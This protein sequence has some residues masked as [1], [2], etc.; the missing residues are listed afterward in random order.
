MKVVINLDLLEAERDVPKKVIKAPS[1][2]SHGEHKLLWSN[3]TILICN[4]SMEKHL[5]N[6]VWTER[7]GE[8]LQ[9][10]WCVQRQPHSRLDR[11][12]QMR[13]WRSWK[14]LSA[15]SDLTLKDAIGLRHEEEATHRYR[16]E[17]TREAVVPAMAAKS[18]NRR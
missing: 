5:M 13:R 2:H 11:Y 6:S 10:L 17:T 15:K 3:D 18:Q 4:A 1:R 7:I 9:I 16:H 12:W 14:K 8:N